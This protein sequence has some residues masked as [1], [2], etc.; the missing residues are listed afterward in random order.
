MQR[1]Y[2]CRGIRSPHECLRYDIK[3]SDGEAPAIE[4]WEMW[5]TPSLLLLLGPLWLEVVVPNRLLS[6][7]M[8]QTV[9]KLMNDDKLCA[10]KISGSFKNVI[11]KMCSEIIYI[12]IYLIHMYKEDW[13]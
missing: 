11:Y 3:P 5:S 9:Y 4:I 12:Y 2:N 7:Q 6:G 8:E 13:H 1:L 10:K